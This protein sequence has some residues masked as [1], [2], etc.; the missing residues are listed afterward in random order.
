MDPASTLAALTSIIAIVP[1][2][3]DILASAG[4]KYRN[5]RFGP[6]W[7]TIL[8]ASRLVDTDAL[9]QQHWHINSWSDEEVSSWK[10]SHLA[11]CNAIAVAV[12]SAHAI[13]EE[14]V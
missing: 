5:A 1:K 7:G 13:S 4:F 10:A 3:I 6:V 11:S 12:G 9:Q 2:A 8:Y 14:R